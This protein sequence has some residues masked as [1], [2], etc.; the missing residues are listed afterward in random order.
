MVRKIYVGNLAYS[1]TEDSLRK[2]FTQIRK[3]ESA[4]IVCDRKIGKSRGVGFVE[5]STEEDAKKAVSALHR[6]LYEGRKL[7]DVM[8]VPELR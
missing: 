2:L 5:M 3:G 6:K 8:T 4:I 7:Q 1:A